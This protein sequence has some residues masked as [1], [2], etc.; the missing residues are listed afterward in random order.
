MA[1]VPVKREYLCEYE[2]GWGLNAYLLLARSQAEILER[3]P[4][5]SVVE[6]DNQDRVAPWAIERLRMFPGPGRAPDIAVAARSPEERLRFREAQESA[7]ND[8]AER[9]ASHG[10]PGASLSQVKSRQTW[11]DIDDDAEFR[12]QM[13]DLWKDDPR[14]RELPPER[15]LF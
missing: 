11:V 1:S 10:L 8:T 9:M 14:Y 13:H 7:W 2:H 15:R 3:Y 12:M 5:F 4:L 6:P